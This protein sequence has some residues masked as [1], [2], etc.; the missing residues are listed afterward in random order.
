MLPR[1]VPV[2]IPH[3]QHITYKLN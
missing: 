3:H 2:S 1:H